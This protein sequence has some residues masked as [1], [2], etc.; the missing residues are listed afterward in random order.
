[1]SFPVVALLDDFNRAEVVLSNGGKWAKLKSS[2]E[3]ASANGS[4]YVVEEGG[5]SEQIAEQ[6]CSYWTPEEFT[7]PGVACL[8][9][10][11]KSRA[12]CLFACL[13]S[14][15]TEATG[16]Q[17]RAHVNGEGI[18]F[19]K[20]QLV[21]FEA[22]VRTLLGEAEKVPFTTGTDLI[23]LSVQGGKVIGWLKK[24][25]GEWEVVIEKADSKW[26]KGYVGCGGAGTSVR[27]D[28][29][30]AGSSE[31]KKESEKFEASLPFQGILIPK[32]SGKGTTNTVGMIIG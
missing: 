21:K 7:E 10:T 13:Q 8:T 4:L 14:P 3:N 9:G 19:D 6:T 31:S 18:E 28:N 29:F 12:M 26:T 30:K 25:A 27:L 32:V 24:G 16:Y 20:F 11:A 15:S 5:D 23:G 17:L 2:G 1:M 22:G